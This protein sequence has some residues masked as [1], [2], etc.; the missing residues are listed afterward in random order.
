MKKKEALGIL[1]QEKPYKLLIRIKDLEGGQDKDR[2]C[3]ALI[4]SINCTYSHG[5][6]LLKKLE[7]TGLISFEKKGRKNIVKLTEK[8]N[9]IIDHFKKIKEQLK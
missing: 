9:K 6:K 2:S 7:K 1:F 3:S 8:G 5:L 4:K